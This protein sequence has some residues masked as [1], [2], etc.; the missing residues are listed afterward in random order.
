MDC[1][2]RR[3]SDRLGEATIIFW[4]IQDRVTTNDREA[5]RCSAAVE[6]ESTGARS[7]LPRMPGW[8]SLAQRTHS[9]QLDIAGDRR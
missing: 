8:I 1:P 9:V 7:P 2:R 3:S 6:V 4:A 5:R